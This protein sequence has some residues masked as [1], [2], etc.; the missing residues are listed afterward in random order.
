MHTPMPH[1]PHKPHPIPVQEP[2]EPDPDQDPYP[3]EPDEGLVHPAI[4]DDEE[5]DR[6]VDPQS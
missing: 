5:H 2:N 6:M 1:T 3:V 4:R